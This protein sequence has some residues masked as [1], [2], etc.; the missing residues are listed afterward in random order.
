MLPKFC[1]ELEIVPAGIILSMFVC[2][3]E[4]EAFNWATEALASIFV[5]NAELDVFNWA[6]EALASIFVCKTELDAFN[7]AV[8]ANELVCELTTND[9]VC[10]FWI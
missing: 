9:P 10:E 8:V 7:E 4:L 6:T 5:C 2:S 1:N 3:A